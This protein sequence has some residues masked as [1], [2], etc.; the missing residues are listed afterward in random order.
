MNMRDQADPFN[1]KTH[2]LG[3]QLWT[4]RSVESDN[5]KRDVPK[6]LYNPV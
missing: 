3:D 1:T 5:Q 6:A 2:R 4:Q